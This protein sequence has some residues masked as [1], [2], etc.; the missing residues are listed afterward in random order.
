GS[1]C[2][3][4]RSAIGSEGVLRLRTRTSAPRRTMV[5]TISTI[6]TIG[7][8]LAPTA[9]AGE[10]YRAR[11]LRLVNATR[12]KHDLH[13]LRIDKSLTR[14]AMRHTHR[15]IAKNEIYDPRNLSKILADE[16]WDD[17]GASVVGCADT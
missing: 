9:Q 5:L 6:L 15:M 11:M 8:V 7:I 17:V 13:T 10:G 1:G 2:N 3:V 14:D 16:P 12:D 4:R